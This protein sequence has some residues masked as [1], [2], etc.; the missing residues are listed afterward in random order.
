MSVEIGWTIGEI[1]KV[2]GEGLAFV[3]LA[4]SSLAYIGYHKA[5]HERE[6]E[7]LSEVAAHCVLMRQLHDVTMESCPIV[8]VSERQDHIV[9]N[10]GVVVRKLDQLVEKTV[11]VERLEAKMDISALDRQRLND[12]VDA[13]GSKLDELRGHLLVGREN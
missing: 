3:G 8:R 9:E 13:I 1:I 5:Q 2:T 6:N 12:K 7:K 4:V 11:R 10:V